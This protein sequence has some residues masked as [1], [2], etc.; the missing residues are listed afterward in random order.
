MHDEMND[1]HAY[2]IKNAICGSQ[3]P[4]VLHSVSSWYRQLLLITPLPITQPRWNF[5]W[6]KLGNKNEEYAKEG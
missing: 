4:G 1:A 2:E 3:T 5:K 6:H